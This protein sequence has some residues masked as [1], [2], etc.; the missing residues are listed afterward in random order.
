MNTV[1]IYG[2]TVNTWKAWETVT[3]R[4]EEKER[5]V[6]VQR[7]I[8]YGEYDEEGNLVATGTEDFS[9]ER[10]REL[11]TQWIWGW[12]GEKRNRGGHRSFECMGTIQFNLNQKSNVMKLLRKKYRDQALIQLRTF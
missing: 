9:R 2:K 3:V 1:R 8:E 11:D 6:I 7:E 4:G 12:D 5:E 10:Y